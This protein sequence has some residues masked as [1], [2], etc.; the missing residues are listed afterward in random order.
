MKVTIIQR[1]LPHYRVP[2]FQSLDNKLHALGIDFQLIYGL[3]YPGTVPKSVVCEEQWAK[4]I[5]NR[6]IHVFAKQLV[7]QPC[8]DLIDDSDLL[9]FEQANFLLLNYWLLLKGKYGGK[10][11]LAYW[12]HGKNMQA[13]SDKS[14]SEKIKKALINKVDWWFAYTDLTISVINEAG[15]PLDKM[16]V[17]QNAVDTSSLKAALSELTPNEVDY[18]RTSL[19]LSDGPIALY[20]GG[21]Y[22]NKK[23]D[24]LIQSSVAIRLLIPGFQLLLIGDGPDQHKAEEADDRYEWIHFFGSQFGTDRAVYFKMADVFLMPGLVGLAILDSF[25][26]GLPIFTTDI[27]IHSPEITYL[28]DGKNG[29]MSP[30]SVEAYSDSVV[31]YLLTDVARKKEVKLACLASADCYTLDN[32][33]NRFVKGIHECLSQGIR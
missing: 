3:E 29:F 28:K 32:M 2:L 26:A 12:G 23:L 5:E 17:L 27:P 7:W 20:C 22:E 4:Q 9:V 31:S 25:V 10:A 16:T 15:F 21:M 8:L 18:K 11:K 19:Q 14:I 30:F 6:Y 13:L 33:I 24:F 1:V